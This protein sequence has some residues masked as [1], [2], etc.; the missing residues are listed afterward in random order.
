MS[1]NKRVFFYKTQRAELESE[2][3]TLESL[4][5]YET[6]EESPSIKT[7]IKK[8]NL[9]KRSYIKFPLQHET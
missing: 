8:L 3:F 2:E 7:I 9:N 6:P 5:E 1:R 4:E